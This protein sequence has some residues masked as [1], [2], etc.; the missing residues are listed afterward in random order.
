M[1]VMV[2]MRRTPVALLESYYSLGKTGSR[3]VVHMRSLPEKTLHWLSECIQAQT[4]LVLTTALA[5]SVLGRC[6]TQ[7]SGPVDHMEVSTGV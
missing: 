7:Q 4:Q 5:L 6:W 3:C 2:Q 1:Y